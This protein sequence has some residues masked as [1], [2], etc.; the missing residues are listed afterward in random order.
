MKRWELEIDFGAYGFSVGTGYGFAGRIDRALARDAH[1]LP[2]LPGSALKGKLRHAAREIA[3]ALGHTVCEEFCPPHRPACIVCRVFGSPFA[4]GKLFVTDAR[5]AAR[6][7]PSLGLVSHGREAAPRVWME[8]SAT[9][10]G[11]GLGVA[12]PGLRYSAECS[13]EGLILRARLEGDFDKAV[14]ADKDKPEERLLRAA[15]RTIRFAGGGSAR[16][17]GGCQCLL[18]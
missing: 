2:Y 9:A 16:G 11:R 5:C 17:L 8:R 12:E 18:L 4:A 6:E 14:E 1:G 10:I 13:P 15:C 3:G 7:N